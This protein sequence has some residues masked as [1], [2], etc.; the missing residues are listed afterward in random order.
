MLSPNV[1]LWQQTLLLAKYVQCVDKKNKIEY[2]DN[3]EKDLN[4]AKDKIEKQREELNIQKAKKILN[5]S[6]NAKKVNATKLKIESAEN[7]TNNSNSTSINDTVPVSNG[8]IT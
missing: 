2:L 8:T 6:K 1:L 3:L 4:E 5:K 7:A